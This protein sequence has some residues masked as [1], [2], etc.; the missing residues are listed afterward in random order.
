MKQEESGECAQALVWAGQVNS[1]ITTA[2][3][4]TGASAARGNCTEVCYG[5]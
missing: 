1:A 4:A 5:D 3:K 2:S